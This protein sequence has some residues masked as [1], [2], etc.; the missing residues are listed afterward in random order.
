MILQNLSVEVR[1]GG[2]AAPSR[3]NDGRRELDGRATQRPQD[4][5]D[6]VILPEE[7]R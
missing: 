5:L 7:Q 3:C 6:V 2:S 4:G 1:G